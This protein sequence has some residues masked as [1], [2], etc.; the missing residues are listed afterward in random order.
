M[1]SVYR[2]LVSVQLLFNGTDLC[3]QLVSVL[4]PPLA[5][6]LGILIHSS[7]LDPALWD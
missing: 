3:L 5:L 7:A 4:C 2:C 1:V 6:L